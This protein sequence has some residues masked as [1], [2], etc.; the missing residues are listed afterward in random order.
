MFLLAFF[1]SLGSTCSIAPRSHHLNLPVEF[2][3]WCS[4]WQL[5]QGKKAAYL[6]AMQAQ[7]QAIT[8]N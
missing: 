3:T 4:T 6:T 7:E 5:E 2:V 1:S 8:S